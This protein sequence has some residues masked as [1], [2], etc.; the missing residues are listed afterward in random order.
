MSVYAEGIG[1]SPEG[2]E[3]DPEDTK[4]ERSEELTGREAFLANAR[5][6]EIIDKGDEAPDFRDEQ[7][8]PGETIIN[9]EH[10][11][12]PKPVQHPSSLKAI[13][14]LTGVKGTGEIGTEGPSVASRASEEGEVEG[15][16]RLYEVVYGRDSL[17]VATDIA[18]YYPNLLKAT[19]SEL[20]PWQGVEDNL[21]SKEE[22][23]RIVHETRSPD[24]PIAQRITK[25]RGWAWPYY[26]TVDA[27]P[28]Y[29]IGMAKVVDKEGPG[30]LS[31]TYQGR[32]GK[33]HTMLDSL[34]N[35]L[36]WL[37]GRLG[38]NPEGLL[39]F[40]QSKVI[41]DDAE[42]WKDSPDAYFH[43]DGT[44]ANREFGIASVEVQALVHNALHD[45][46]TVYEKIAETMNNEDKSSYLSKAQGFREKAGLLKESVMDKFWVED[47]RG[48]YFALAT[49]RDS[50][51]ELAPLKV[52]SSNMGHLLNSRMLDGDDPETVE[53]REAVIKTIFS[54]EM[55]NVSGVRTISSQ[56][57]RFRPSGYHDGSVWLWDT[58]YVAQGLE[59]HGYFGLAMALKD[60]IW[61]VMDKT[62]SFPEYAR[63]GDDPEPKLTERVIDVWDETNGIKHRIEQPP[64]EIQA[65]TVAAILASKHKHDP[66]DREKQMPKEATDPEKREF[67]KKIL[68]KIPKIAA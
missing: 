28:M 24:D 6:T 49:E 26:S 38:S 53:K 3:L 66:L 51:G 47:D 20:A 42:V 8:F 10:P 37:E 52:R 9:V 45:A 32:D 27:T 21:R 46:A 19:V 33:E 18:D 31:Q 41:D 60:R 14:K 35:S 63:G 1:S 4:I 58:Y 12:L 44:L 57:A 61:N 5:P 48:G 15:A 22:P 34:N 13:L 29:I 39:E 68:D 43:A 54:S 67:E 64:Q 30:F 11:D 7:L 62:K 17:R 50:G 16:L 23:G 65:W 36:G 56:E 2:M 55:L 40:T 59:R 25:E